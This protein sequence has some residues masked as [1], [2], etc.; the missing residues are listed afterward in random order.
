MIIWCLFTSWTGFQISIHAP[1]EG[2]DSPG[3]LRDHS[4]AISI[5]APREGSDNA[6]VFHHKGFRDLNPRSPRGE[7]HGDGSSDHC[8]FII[9][10][11]APC[12]GSDAWG[13]RRS[14]LR[15]NFNPRSPRGE[16]PS[17]PERATSPAYF[18]PRSPRGE[19]PGILQH[20]TAGQADFNPRSPRGERLPVS[21]YCSGNAGISIH[22]PREGS[23]SH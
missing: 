19:R 11:H 15:R 2:S 23:D 7:R 6:P 22:A 1:R 5:H 10:I 13:H 16:R 12:E 17:P 18:N 3:L 8:G 14:L 20:E 9:S 21:D 4:V